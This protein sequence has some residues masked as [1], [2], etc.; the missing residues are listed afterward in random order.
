LFGNDQFVIAMENSGTSAQVYSVLDGRCLGEMEMPEWNRLLT[1]VG[2]KAVTW[3]SQPTGEY[4]L[5]SVDVMTSTEQ[6]SHSFAV[7]AQVDVAPGNLLAVVEPSGRYWVVDATD[8]KVLVNHESPLS[9][10]IKQVHLLAGTDTL[11]IAVEDIRPPSRPPGMTWLNVFP[12]SLQFNGDLLCFE[13]RTG[14]SLW[15]RPA[16]IQNQVLVLSQ[17]MDLPVVAFAGNYQSEAR[18]DRQQKSSL[19]LLEK[20]SGRVLFADEKLP[21]SGNHLELIAD[22]AEHSLSANLMNRTIKLA[23][24]EAPRPPEP[25]LTSEAKVDSETGPRGL[26]RIFQKLGIVN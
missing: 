3:Q 16:R 22:P 25:P 12:D 1:T 26:Y 4:R 20:A 24:T 17:P 14:E 15:P 6:W 5:S 11:T 10:N 13:R 19:V 18:G 2:T 9:I 23:F 7:G 8:G 21:Q